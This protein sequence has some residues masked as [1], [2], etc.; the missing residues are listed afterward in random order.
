MQA[1]KEFGP[2][3]IIDKSSQLIKEED[4]PTVLALATELVLSD[5]IIADKEKELLEY[6]ALK[7]NIDELLASKIIEVTLIKNKDNRILVARNVPFQ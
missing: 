4:R 1:K 3:H 6:V 7:L 5:G 2:Q